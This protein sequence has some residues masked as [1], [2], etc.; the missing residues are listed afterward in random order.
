MLFPYRHY[1]IWKQF[2]RPIIQKSRAHQAFR[3]RGETPLVVDAGCGTGALADLLATYYDVI[4]IDLSPE[5]LDQAAQN[6]P[7]KEI[8]WVC[9]DISKMNTGRKAAAVFAVTDTL[10]HLTDIRKLKA[11]LKRAY[12]SLE[13]GGYLFFDV[14]T[15]LFF[16]TYYDENSCSFEEFDWGSFFWTCD[17]HEKKQTAVY[18]ISFFEKCGGEDALYRRY[19]EQITERIWEPEFLQECL[20]EAGFSNVDIYTDIFHGCRAESSVFGLKADGERLYFVCEKP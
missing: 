10:N 19:D 9:Q 2:A 20:R 4:G 17:Y 1:V 16:R 18:Q 6:Y 3:Q 7:D 5:M 8:L 12:Q 15:D 14:V 11:F 13:S